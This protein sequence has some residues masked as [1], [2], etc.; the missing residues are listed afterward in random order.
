MR[1]RPERSIDPS[2]SGPGSD[3][4]LASAFRRGDR[5]ALAQLYER[6]K[7]PLYLFA[8]RM[9]GDPESAIDL[10]Q[11]VFLRL[12]E[13]REQLD[14][15]ERFRSWLFTAARNRCL[16][17]LRHGRRWQP[18]DQAPAD[19]LVAAPPSDA[20]EREEKLGRLR[21]ALESLRVEYREVLILREYQELSYREI[22]E[23]TGSTESA[24]KSRLWKARQTLHAALAP[25][26]EGKEPG[27]EL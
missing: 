5:R 27:R 18:I 3:A 17:E 9:L 26:S 2:R 10:V 15:P 1:S 4:E 11:E 8:R 7:R 19:R 20:R 22:A 13:R 16:T 14:R 6:Y 23:V 12:H 21:D 24:V 25:G